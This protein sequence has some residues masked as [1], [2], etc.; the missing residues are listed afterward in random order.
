[1]STPVE[2]H[3]V[4]DPGEDVYVEYT[5]P[6]PQQKQQKSKCGLS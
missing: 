6:P 3:P 5:S 4:K 1:M 2:Q